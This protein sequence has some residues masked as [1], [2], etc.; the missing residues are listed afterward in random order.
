MMDYSAM[1]QNRKSVRGFLDKKVSAAALAEVEAYYQ[2]ECQRLVPALKTELRIFGSEAR[3]ALEGSA[4][5]ENFLI[6]APQYLVLLSAEGEYAEEN[7]GFMMEDMILKL[8]EMDLGSCW[9]TFADADKVKEALKIDSSMKVAAIVAFGY[10]QKLSKRLRLNILSMS[11]VDVQAK[12]HYYDPK[13]SVYDMVFM[14]EWGK[15][16]GL[17]EH[18]GFYDDML[19]E[20]FYASTLTP[21]YLNRQPYG[22]VLRDHRL[23][24]VRK[25][26]EYTDEVS[27]KLGLGIVMLH[28]SGTASKWSSKISWELGQAEGISLP[29]GHTVAAVCNL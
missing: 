12:R 24:L 13:V 6:G 4:G 26:D 23:F 5:Y 11:N 25:P 27:A 20:A 15:S 22:F 28:F 3:E 18:I 21:S 2:K 10:A 17:D 9:I 19:W 16:D 7:A 1:I 8:T 14:N 29:E